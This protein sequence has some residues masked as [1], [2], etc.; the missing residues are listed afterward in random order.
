MGTVP[1]ATTDTARHPTGVDRQGI[2]AAIAATSP[3]GID[4]VLRDT[5]NGTAGIT[6]AGTMG[7][8]RR[9]RRPA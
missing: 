1:L 2:T 3:W 8:A 4:M 7:G 9:P 5:T 6:T